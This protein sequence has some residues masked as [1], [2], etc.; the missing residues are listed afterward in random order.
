MVLSGLALSGAEGSKDILE[1]LSDLSPA[2]G[3]R[4]EIAVHNNPIYS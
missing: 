3:E 4:I 2:Y 1:A